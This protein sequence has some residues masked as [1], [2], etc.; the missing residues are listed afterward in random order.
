MSG[1]GVATLPE[2]EIPHDVPAERAAPPE[3]EPEPELGPAE[4]PAERAVPPEPEPEPELVYVPAERAVSREV[5]V[6]EEPGTSYIVERA[7][8]TPGGGDDEGTEETPGLFDETPEF[9][10]DTQE[11]QVSDWALSMPAEEVRRGMKRRSSRSPKRSRAGGILGDKVV[12]PRGIAAETAI[13]KETKRWYACPE[14]CGRI[15]IKFSEFRAH[16]GKTHPKKKDQRCTCPLK[17]CEAS[18]NNPAEWLAHLASRHP[19]FVCGHDIDFFDN[20]F[21]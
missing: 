7:E 12:K 10:M 2:L 11:T 4:V 1:G 19:N 18:C 3:P 20:Y 13:L 6:P 5:H 14:G 16:A 15:F 21:Y 17:T 8:E 9:V